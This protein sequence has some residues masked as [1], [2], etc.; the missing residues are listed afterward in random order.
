MTRSALS[1]ESSPSWFRRHFNED[2]LTI[3]SGRNASQAE[4]EV[5]GIVRELAVTADDRVLDLCCGFGRHLSAFARRGIRAV[6]VDLSLALLR[7]VGAEMPCDACR[8]VCADMRALP[9]ASGGEVFSVVLNL[10]TS[11]GYFDEDEE[12]FLALREIERVL[13]PGGRFAIDL[14]NAETAVSA[15][16]PRTERRAGPFRLVEERQY[17]ARR[18]RIEKRIVLTRPGEA[19]ERRYFESV[20][21]FGAEEIVGFLGRA[22]LR[23]DRL[24]GD[25]DGRGFGP[26]TARMIVLGTKPE[27]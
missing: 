5:A 13:A 23:T 15:L 1:G 8:V 4:A 11:F 22:G 20:R 19:E 9:F 3:Y 12:N 7:R 24:L 26:G 14:L 27:S 2:Y 17:D 21:V 25:F 18:R 6:G 16:E 10:F